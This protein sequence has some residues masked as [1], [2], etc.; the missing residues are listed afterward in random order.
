MKKAA[1][2][3]LFLFTLALAGSFCIY[4]DNDSLQSSMTVYAQPKSTPKKAPKDT[5]SSTKQY[6]VYYFFNNFR[7]PSCKKIEGY[8]SET[9]NG[10][11]S[12]EVKAGRISWKPVNL[13]EPANK[14]FMQDY[15]LVTKSVVIVE[16][17]NGKEA[18]WKNLDKIWEHLRNKS[19]F[20]AYVEGEIRSFVGGS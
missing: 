13:D 7:C 14:H 3:L 15:K 4:Q 10:K 16:M 20:S 11:F 5:A 9:V 17:V 18:R 8:T 12:S 1:F 2:L 6:I 19:R